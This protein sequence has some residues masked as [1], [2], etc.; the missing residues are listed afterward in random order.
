ML[1]KN[2]PPEIEADHEP[3]VAPPLTDPVS[4][5]HELTQTASGPEIVTKISGKI[6]IEPEIILS[7][8]SLVNVNV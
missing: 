5:I 2:S 8:H 6:S 4:S 1:G 3:D 7:P